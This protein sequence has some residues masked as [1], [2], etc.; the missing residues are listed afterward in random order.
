MKKLIYIL[1]PVVCLII[2]GILGYH[3]LFNNGEDRPPRGY[4]NDNDYELIELQ[5]NPTIR[6]LLRGGVP[7]RITKDGRTIESEATDLAGAINDVIDHL[8]YNNVE[9]VTV[10][11]ITG[12]PTDIT[13]VVTELEE[14]NITV[15][16]SEAVEEREGQVFF[17]GHWAPAWR[18]EWYD[19]VKTAC[20]AEGSPYPTYHTIFWQ[21]GLPIS[22]CEIH[23]GQ[24]GTICPRR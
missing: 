23:D 16:T 19:Y 8:I 22:C 2:G 10:N 20:F 4:S 1:I 9:F 18:L 14:R 6:I 7:V 17:Y 11:V 3:F 21:G 13:T 24:G 15:N 12:N 5:V